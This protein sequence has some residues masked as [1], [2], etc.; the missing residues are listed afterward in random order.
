M[1][2]LPSLR[3][4]GEPSCPP[5]SLLQPRCPPEM[6]IWGKKLPFV[7]MLMSLL[8]A[9]QV[10]ASGAGT[11]P[12]VSHASPCGSGK[13]QEHEIPAEEPATRASPRCRQL[14]HHL[15]AIFGLPVP[16]ISPHPQDAGARRLHQHSR[17]LLS[18]Q[19]L[20]VTA[21]AQ[22]GEH[23]PL[24][25]PPVPGAGTQTRSRVVSSWNQPGWLLCPKLSEERFICKETDEFS[26]CQPACGPCTPQ[27]QGRT[28][29]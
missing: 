4:G 28:M 23:Q 26:S 24:P 25:T 6:R 19:H 16:C 29:L 5:A 2:R 22:Q 7:A 14:S 20:M 21:A 11:F 17:W 10:P 12:N 27:N 8:P 3:R 15:A 13:V 18:T 1:G 9:C